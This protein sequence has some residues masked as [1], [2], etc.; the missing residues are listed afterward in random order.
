[1]NRSRKYILTRY[2]EKINV[3]ATGQE[4]ETKTGTPGSRAE[5]KNLRNLEL[6][7]EI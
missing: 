6:N 3:W 1:M 2:P 5:K 7:S 4:T